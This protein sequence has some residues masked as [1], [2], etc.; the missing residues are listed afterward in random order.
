MRIRSG[1]VKSGSFYLS[2]LI[3]ISFY[4]FC[5]FLFVLYLNSP[6]VKKFDAFTKTTVLELEIM[7]LDTKELSKRNK[8]DIK[9]TKKSHETVKKST[10]KSAKQ[11]NNVKSLFANVKTKEAKVLDK[12][13]NNVVKSEVASRF[14]SKFEKQR[15]S[16]NVSV[17]KLLDS[18]KTKA[19][20]MASTDSKNNQDPYFSK[21]YE[22]LSSRW[23]PM[24]IVD[25]LS[26]KVI[27]MISSSGIFDYRFLSY[28]GDERFDDSLRGFLESQK[29]EA[30]PTH[31]RGS[32]QEIEV[33]FGSLKG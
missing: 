19:A 30:Y 29:S 10:S 3:A 23:Q 2:G 6:E 9:D 11:T 28:S 7:I 8:T 24:L 25:G 27:V 22:L 32:T 4:L 1:T 15:K 17:S 20:L 21:I 33:T 13:V 18:V 31:D 5:C 12:T 26:A 14:K 16:S